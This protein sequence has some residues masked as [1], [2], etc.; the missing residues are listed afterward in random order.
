MHPTTQLLETARKQVTF[1]IANLS[2]LLY[3]SVEEFEQFR[4]FL[5]ECEKNPE[6]DN[7]IDY[8]NLGRKE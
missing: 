1:D 2:P 6:L 3:G 5:L 4:Q 7:T 8:H